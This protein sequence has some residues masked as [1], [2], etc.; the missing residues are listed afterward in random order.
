M[1]QLR[2][3]E[4]EGEKCCHDKKQSDCGGVAGNAFKVLNMSFA[5]IANLCDSPQGC[6]PC[7][8]PRALPALPHVQG[9]DAGAAAVRS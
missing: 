8:S 9:S 5:T 4:W 3:C 6:K 2:S 1:A 7:Q